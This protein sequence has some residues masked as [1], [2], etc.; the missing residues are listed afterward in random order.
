MTSLADISLP[1]LF[2][3]T[4]NL[5]AEA[6]AITMQW[7]DNGVEVETK[8]DNTP[9]TIADKT[10]EAFLRERISRAFP[11]DAIVGEE[12]DDREG[13][14]GRTW[15]IDPIDGTKSFVRGVPLYSSLLAVEDEQGPLIGVIGLPAMREI[16]G[17]ARGL[18]T[19]RNDERVQV[20]ET[21]SIE[22]AMVLTSGFD[23]WTPEQ[24]ERL[25]VRKPQLRTWGDGYGWAMVATGRADA[26]IDPTMARWDIAPMPIILSEAGGRCTDYN[27]VSRTDSGPGVASNGILHDELL[28]IMQP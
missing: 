24:F 22:N 17:A 10:A 1:E 15:I 6:G 7:F 3:F 16:V 18:G 26:I 5:V 14:S 11:D 9:V 28:A 13:S 12:E 27:G 25:H 8:S 19:W 20:S 21:K 2:M 23:P 4:R